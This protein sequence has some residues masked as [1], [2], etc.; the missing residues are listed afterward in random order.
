VNSGA[1]LSITSTGED[2][3]VAAANAKTVVVMSVPGAV[4]TPWRHKVGAILCNFM[5]GQ[6]AGNAIADV[7]FGRV[8]PT[9]KLP[10][11][12]PA[13]EDED[14]LSPT[15]WPGFPDPANPR[16]AIYSEELLVGYRHYDAL[17]L[18]PAFPFGHG[19][20][21]TT[22]GYSSLTVAAGGAVSFTMTN[23]GALAGAEVAQLYLSFPPSAGEPPKVLRRFRKV[24]LQPGKSVRVA[25]A[26]LKASADMAVWSEKAHAWTVVGGDF[27]VLVG[28]SSRDIRLTG[29]LRVTPPASARVVEEEEA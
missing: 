19:L 7:L 3:A 5:P 29:V 28:A 11:T 4:L 8:N 17:G 22:F 6:Q 23:L 12:M 24:E 15:Q 26:P 9:A 18:E 27:G 10:I 16:F 13:Y 25:F 1:S 14:G 2:A 20:S 21:Y